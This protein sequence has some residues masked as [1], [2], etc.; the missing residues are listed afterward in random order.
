MYTIQ[1]EQIVKVPSS[2]KGPKT[3]NYTHD[4]L[5]TAARN[6]ASATMSAGMR[7]R[8]KRTF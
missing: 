6:A 3:L 4:D 5:E 2:K 8:M 7:G 1:E